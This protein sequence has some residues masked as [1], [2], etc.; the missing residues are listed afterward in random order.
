MNVSL[1]QAAAAM[2][3]S[4]R[5]QEVIAGNLS[6]SMV[7]GYKRQEMTFESVSANSV[8]AAGS[9]VMPRAVLGTNFSA[10]ETQPT[11][12]ATDL[13]I[14]GPGFFEVELPDGSQAYT[15]LGSMQIGPTGQL[16]SKDGNTVLGQGG[17]IQLD[18]NERGT[19]TISSSGEISQGDVSRGRLKLVEFANP[20]ALRMVGQGLFVA[21]RPGVE[22]LDAVNSTVSQGCLEAA[23]TVPMI[24]M[25]E[26]ITSMRQFEANQKVLQMHD[27][28]MN[29]A[30]T[31]LGNPSAS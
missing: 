30:I 15:K 9:A 7:P 26:L 17:P 21:D 13:A 27:E 31:D 29:R 6:S 25:A 8:G 2:N 14:N 19:L 16:M 11:G 24:E 28:R 1:Y 20:Q 3:A 12:V 22:P 4:A 5:W 23:N 18:P 10:G